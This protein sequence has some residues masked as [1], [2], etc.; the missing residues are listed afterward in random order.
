MG[1]AQVI[2]ILIVLFVVG[3]LP[4]FWCNNIYEKTKVNLRHWVFF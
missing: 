3:L 4:A 2:I 1:I